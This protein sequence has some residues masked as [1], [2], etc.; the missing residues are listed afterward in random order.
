MERPETPEEEREEPVTEQVEEQVDEQT[1][2]KVEEREPKEVTILDTELEQLQE[3]LADTKNRYML[4]L[5]ESEN[6]R[7]RMQKERQEL[8]QYAVEK[9][10][11]EFLTPLDRMESALS[12]ADKM[13]DEVKNWA[14][15]FEMILTQFKEVLTENGVVAFDSVGERFDP[16]RHEAVE[17][18]ESEEHAPDTVVEEFVKGYIRGKRVV[19]PARVKVAKAPKKEELQEKLS[20]E[21]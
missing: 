16:H 1:E 20:E 13:S 21:K 18:V 6:A 17:S 5:A 7:K 3:E 10:L 8:T 12:F 2:E 14:I 19:R 15:G 9:M 11:S 4:L